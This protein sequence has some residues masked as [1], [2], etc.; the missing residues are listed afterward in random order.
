MK[1]SFRW[2]GIV[3]SILVCIFTWQAWQRNHPLADPSGDLI[4][5]IEAKDYRFVAV[6]GFSVDVPSVPQGV[7]NSFVIKYNY[8]ILEGTSDNQIGFGEII[9]NRKAYKYAQTYNSLML[10]ELIKKTRQRT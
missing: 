3:L 2:I 4:R 8:R 6:R 9:Y 5:A 1:F 7:E 10:K